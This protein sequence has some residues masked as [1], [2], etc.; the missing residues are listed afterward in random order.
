LEVVASIIPKEKRT[1]Y[2]SGGRA[3][4]GVVTDEMASAAGCNPGPIRL[5]N[6]TEGRVSGYGLEH[7]L[8]KPGRL[9]QIEQLGFR[10]VVG[11][12]QFVASN[13]AVIASQEDGRLLFEAERD[14]V[15]HHLVCQW[16]NEL[17]I[18]SVTTIVPKRASRGL[19]V[20][21]KRVEKAV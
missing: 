14:G 12:V 5:L 7:L 9:A 18:W 10:E 13:F 20:V 4:L 15:F 8:A 3:D 2:G 16:D 1:V 11:Y 19:N 6:G 21:W 17:G